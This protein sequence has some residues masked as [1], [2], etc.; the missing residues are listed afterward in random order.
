VN[1]TENLKPGDD[2]DKKRT[3]GANIPEIYATTAQVPPDLRM[4]AMRAVA[5]RAHGAED[6]RDLLERLGLIDPRTPKAKWRRAN[7]PKAAS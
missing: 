4:P 3:V 5:A 1:L 7:T 2:A 6:A